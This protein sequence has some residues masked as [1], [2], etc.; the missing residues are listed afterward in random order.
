MYTLNDKLIVIKQMPFE[1]YYPNF[2]KDPKKHYLMDVFDLEKN[3]NL[4]VKARYANI[5]LDDR[6]VIEIIDNK[7]IAIT[8]GKYIKNND[9]GRNK[10]GLYKIL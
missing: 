4:N 2:A 10:V 8:I 9:F 3:D 7:Y 1:N 5:D 6:H